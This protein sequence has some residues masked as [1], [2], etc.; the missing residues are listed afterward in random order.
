[1]KNLYILF[2]IIFTLS[3]TN[4][5]NTVTF[6][7]NTARIDVGPNGMYLG[8]GYFGDAM[9]HAMTDADGDG[10]WTVT[11]DMPGNA[12]GKY[13]FLNSPNDGGNWDAKENLDGQSCGDPASHND[14]TLPNITGDMTLSHCFGSCETDGTCTP[15]EK[16]ANAVTSYSADFASDVDVFVAQNNIVLDYN[17]NGYL[18]VSD[19]NSDWW[20]HLR[21]NLPPMD[22]TS[23]T[24]GISL[25]V[26]GQRQSKVKLKLQLGDSHWI[27]WELDQPDFNYTDVGNWQT[28]TWDISAWDNLYAEYMTA[29][30]FFFDVQ[31]NNPSETGADASLDVFDVDDFVFGEFASLS[32]KNNSLSDFTVY[33]NPTTD[34]VNINSANTIDSYRIHDLTGR[35]VKRSSPNSNN[36][37][38]DVTSLNKGVYMVKLNSGD[39]TGSI[40]LVKDN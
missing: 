23:G 3:Q 4:A 29:V 19:T 8:G 27:N 16:P 7:V 24:K 34:F 26:R 5:Q 14:R 20:A 15:T 6:E 9:A 40:K 10:T 28:I 1:M 18:T 11:V 13:I 30:V 38:I 33:P 21:G 2:L 37:R 36:F 32:I 25:Q 17:T 39:K 22:L 12:S 35:V 31:T